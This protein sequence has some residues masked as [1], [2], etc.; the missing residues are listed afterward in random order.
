MQMSYILPISSADVSIFCA[1]L[2][3]LTNGESVKHVSYQS[4]GTLLINEPFVKTAIDL[5]DHGFLATPSELKAYAS[6]AISYKETNGIIVDGVV[7]PTDQVIVATDRTSR[8]MLSSLAARARLS[9]GLTA[10]WK[11]LDG[12]YLHLNAEQIIEL[13]NVVANFVARCFDSEAAIFAS[14]DTGQITTQDQIDQL[15]GKI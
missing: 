2:K 11:S 15:V 12:K 8:A 10:N 5:F 7:E 13:D 9:D 14:V 4:D 1:R 3:D 6:V